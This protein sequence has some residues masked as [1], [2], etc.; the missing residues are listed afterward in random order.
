MIT[1][2]FASVGFLNASNLWFFP[3]FGS[4]LTLVYFRRK[5][6]NRKVISSIL[7]LRGFKSVIS[8]RKKT[9]PP[10]RYYFELFLLFL[11]TLALSGLFIERNHDLTAVLIDNSFSMRSISSPST[12][13]L[14]RAKEQAGNFL[15][16]LSPSSKIFVYKT[17]PS[18][19]RLSE[20]PV[21]SSEAYNLIN[22]IEPSY[23]EDYILDAI[24]LIRDQGEYKSIFVITD[25]IIESKTDAIKTQTV[26]SK[27]ADQN[28]SILDFALKRRDR[29]GLEFTISVGWFGRETG[30]FRLVLLGLSSDLEKETL[31]AEAPLLNIEAGQVRNFTLNAKN[32]EFNGFH[33]KIIP[34]GFQDSIKEDNEAWLPAVKSLSEIL[35]VS[36]KNLTSLG[37]DK[38][39]K[40]Q[41]AHMEPAKLGTKSLTS[42]IV[43]F[44]NIPLEELPPK[45]SLFILPQKSSDTFPFGAVSL[46]SEPVISRWLDSDPILSYINVPVFSLKSAFILEYPR[47]SKE[48]IHVLSGPILV[49]G[50]KDRHRYVATGFDLFPFEGKRSPI[51]AILMLN[52]FKWLEADNQSHSYTLPHKAI[53]VSVGTVSGKNHKGENISIQKDATS[54]KLVVTSEFP[55]IIELKN[56]EGDAE[57]LAVNFFSENESNTFEID[58]LANDQIAKKYQKKMRADIMDAILISVIFFLLIGAL[59]STGITGYIRGGRSE[60]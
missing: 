49:A 35:I 26:S 40:Y 27:Q 8:E 2:L 50:E 14:A 15:S 48:L 47:W 13:R 5:N 58:S 3:L 54:E 34:Q 29:D 39:G 44:H 46:T 56:K 37:L 10:R 9:W 25:K 43:V 60:V 24:K 18:F 45:N 7:L 32:G 57:Y 42:D 53:S 36:S 31:L 41:F 33:V 38:V 23:A 19:T 28:I 21:G 16:S 1:E 30:N 6:K 17:S 51:S 11:S 4:V 52:I 12:T 22:E 59:F 20:N 55:G